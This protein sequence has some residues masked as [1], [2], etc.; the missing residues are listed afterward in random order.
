MFFP[1]PRQSDVSPLFSLDT[2]LLLCTAAHQAD[3]LGHHPN[4]SAYQP[5]APSWS[6]ASFSLWSVC[7][8][9]A[10]LLVMNTVD[11]QSK[12]V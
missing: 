9:W 3:S 10:A 6:A 7:V 4:A 12:L 2:E 8:K 1:L 11:I 5:Q